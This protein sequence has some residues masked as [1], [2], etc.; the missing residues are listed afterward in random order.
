MDNTA[1]KLS[2][3]KRSGNETVSQT[4]YL[5][6]YIGGDGDESWWRV[7]EKVG[8]QWPLRKERNEECFTCGMV[9]V[10][11]DK[12]EH[13]ALGAL[14]QRFYIFTHTRSFCVLPQLLTASERASLRAHSPK[15]EPISLC[16]RER[17]DGSC[18]ML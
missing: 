2:N 11:R 4:I 3:E 14:H 5:Y 6:I 10:E 17:A 12:V 16:G 8:A 9:V 13:V 18:E 7:I 15:R 1:Q